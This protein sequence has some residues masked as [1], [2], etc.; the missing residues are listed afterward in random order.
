MKNIHNII[1]F[2]GLILFVVLVTLFKAQKDRE[3]EEAEQAKAVVFRNHYMIQTKP[4]L[5]DTPNITIPLQGVVVTNHLEEEGVTIAEIEA[6]ALEDTLPLLE[7]GQT[8]TIQPSRLLGQIQHIDSSLNPL[9]KTTTIT[10]SVPD[11]DELLPQGLFVQAQVQISEG[12]KV[13]LIPTSSLLVQHG[14]PFVYIETE[15]GQ[16][17]RRAIKTNQVFG[18]WTSVA[19]GLS[20]GENVVVN[21]TFLIDSLSSE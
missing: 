7:N 3:I 18:S 4:V 8:V 14:R 15:P 9:T 16:Y 1:L 12:E 2:A 17:T 13:L 19:S 5:E 10:L 11:S 20:P 6:Q 21:G